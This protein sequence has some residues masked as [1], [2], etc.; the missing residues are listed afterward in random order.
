MEKHKVLIV[1]DE[2]G[3]LKITK[4][5]LESTGKYIVEIMADA[6]DIISRV[7]SFTPDVILLD[8]VM[9]NMDG[10]ETCK[11]LNDDPAGRGVP[12]ITLTALDREKDKL[13]MYKLG[14]VDFLI[15]PIGLDELVAKIEKAVHNKSS[16]A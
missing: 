6:K 1:D 9:P 11:I 3:F 8:I 4:S 15:K 14:V 13:M 16:R 2:I 5:S 7:N 10:A 12:I